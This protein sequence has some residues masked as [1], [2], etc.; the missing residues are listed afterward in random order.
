MFSVCSPPGGGGGAGLLQSG[1]QS[2]PH[3]L[4]VGLFGEG[5]GLP[6]SGPMSLP[7]GGGTQSLVPYPFWTG[8][9]PFPLG[10]GS[11]RQASSSQD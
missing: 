10:E 11:P 6:V 4:V 5:G 8:Y 9:L 2:L 3:T 1:S 7:E